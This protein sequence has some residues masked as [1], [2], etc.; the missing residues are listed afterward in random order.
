M[1]DANPSEWG[2]TYSVNFQGRLIECAT[3][4]DAANIKVANRVLIKRNSHLYSIDELYRF[5][6]ALTRC[7][8]A[9]SAQLFSH[10]AR[11]QVAEYFAKRIL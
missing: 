3:L 2:R 9:E 5:A 4:E 7:G 11:M 8:H 6:N 10:W 1:Q